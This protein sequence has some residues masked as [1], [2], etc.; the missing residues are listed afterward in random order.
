MVESWWLSLMPRAPVYRLDAIPGDRDFAFTG[1]VLD[2]VGRDP[3]RIGQLARSRQAKPW[4]IEKLMT[5]RDEHE[6]TQFGRGVCRARPQLA[7]TSVVDLASSR[8]LRPDTDV[9][10]WQWR[11]A[12]RGMDSVFFRP[13]R[14]RK[15]APAHREAQAKQVCRGCPVLE[16]CRRHALLVREPHGVWGGLSESERNDMLG[17]RSLHASQPRTPARSDQPPR[18]PGSARNSPADPGNVKHAERGPL[19]VEVLDAIVIE[20]E[21]WRHADVRRVATSMIGSRV[22]V[23]SG[24]LTLIKGG[25]DEPHRFMTVVEVAATLR[26]SRAT[27]YRLVHARRLPAMRVGKSMR[28]SREAVEEY[29]RSAAL[30]G[31]ET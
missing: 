10:D 13:E 28:V 14:E 24:A 12:C 9:W 15:L 17:G 5:R 8:R 29:V 22:S 20:L 18:A 21:A 25:H 19:S 2:T 3:S 11:G 7:V 27:V 6:V 26:V 1:K 31:P 16:L 30:G 23:V 4:E